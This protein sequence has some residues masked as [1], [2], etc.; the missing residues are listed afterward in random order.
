M[1]PKGEWF[2]YIKVP[3]YLET[4]AD[5]FEQ[6]GYPLYIVGGYIRNAILGLN[7]KDI[8]ICSKATNIPLV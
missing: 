2:M 7:D 1:K 6:R 3:S 5:I 4:L 8:D